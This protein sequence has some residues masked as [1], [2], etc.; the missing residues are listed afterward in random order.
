MNFGVRIGSAMVLDTNLSVMQNAGVGGHAQREAQA[1]IGLHRRLNMFLVE[2]YLQEGH[3][4]LY[5]VTFL[6]FCKK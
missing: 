6:L 5:F 2:L 1:R 3:C 4:N